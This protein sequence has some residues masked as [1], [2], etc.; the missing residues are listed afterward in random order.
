[1]RIEIETITNITKIIDAKAAKGARIFRINFHH[2]GLPYDGSLSEN[3]HR[4]P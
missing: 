1:M 4:I 3:L 2:I